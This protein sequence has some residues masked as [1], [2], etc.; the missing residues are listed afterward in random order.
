M[1]FVPPSVTCP[2][3]SLIHSYS[4]HTEIPEELIRSPS[5]PCILGVDEA[6]R[7]PVLGPMV[8]G[9]AYCSAEYRDRIKSHGFMDSKVLDHDTRVKLLRHMCEPGHELFTSIGWTVRV[10]SAKAIA[11]GM[12]RPTMPYNLNTQS[13]DT[14]IQLI[15]DV[16]SQGV[17]IREIFV[18][19]V[20]DP[21]SY[22]AK[23]QRLF[24]QCTV[25]VAK[26]ADSLYPIVSVAS[27]CAK[28]T[29]D[30]A[31]LQA[32]P[33]NSPVDNKENIPVQQNEDGTPSEL[34]L[35]S[36]G[37][38]YPSD[39]RTQTWLK[40]NVDPIFGWEGDAVRYSWSTAKEILDNG[41][42]KGVK[43]KPAVSVNWHEEDDDG[44]SNM[45]ITEFFPNSAKSNRFGSSWYGQRLGAKAF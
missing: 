15:K 3:S 9:V 4:F 31:L 1:P 33:P 37:S 28:V 22:Q 19:T 44:R 2:Q 43:S 24:P 32:V 12:L 16:I 17:N 6:G 8:Y 36:W 34:E 7:G 20:G 5:K 45:Q 42:G 39:A 13:H 25:T 26:K 29:R 21:G 27:I 30:A 10:M 40:N 23:L 41:T 38:G 11:A 14:T 18:D 35:A